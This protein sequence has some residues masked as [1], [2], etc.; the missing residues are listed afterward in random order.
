MNK[1][2]ATIRRPVGKKERKLLLEL[3]ADRLER[4]AAVFGLFNP[5]FISSVTRA[6]ED[7]RRGKIRRVQS[8]AE[9][10]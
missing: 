9:I 8:L 7:F 2:S 6:E 1:I 5:D 4:F 3:D 10:R